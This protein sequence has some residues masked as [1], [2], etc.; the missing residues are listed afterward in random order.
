MSWRSMATAARSPQLGSPFP[1]LDTAHSPS[2]LEPPQRQ[3]P[4]T[5]TRFRFQALFLRSP[6]F[7][8]RR[9]QEEMYSFQVSEYLRLGE[10]EGARGCAGGRAGGRWLGAATAAL[11]ERDHVSENFLLNI[12]Q[13][14]LSQLP[15]YFLMFP[16]QTRALIYGFRD[17]DSPL[18]WYE[19]PKTAATDLTAA[20]A[21]IW[22]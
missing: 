22:P 18:V 14:D 15:F 11:A 13:P 8:P 1:T 21:N 7:L 12:P 17:S 20:P 6:I 5:S 2:A 9:K 19:A 10:L 3:Q 4:R 16:F